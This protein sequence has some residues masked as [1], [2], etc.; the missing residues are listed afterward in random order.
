MGRSKKELKRSIRP[1][2][3]QKRL[4]FSGHHLSHAASAFYPS[5]F[6][7]AA[8]L[9]ID[10]VG[11]WSTASIWKG[12]GNELTLLRE[13]KFPDSLGLLY[14]AFTHFLGFK[15]NN[16]EYKLMG[17]APYGNPGDAQTRDFMRI[18]KTK[19]VEIFED[20][21]IQLHR[22]AFSFEY[23]LKMVSDKNGKLCLAWKNGIL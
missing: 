17:L 18:I 7:E 21:S 2:K 8:V 9:V 13:L 14:S 19:L 20:G 15:V 1:I 11:E 23:G 3:K 4:L 22:K 16:G 6:N 12:V 5:S 10:A